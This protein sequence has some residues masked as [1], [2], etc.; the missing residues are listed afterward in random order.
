MS[1]SRVVRRSNRTEDGKQRLKPF[2]L[3]EA[4]SSGRSPRARRSWTVTPLSTRAS[5]MTRTPTRCPWPRYREIKGERRENERGNRRFD[6][7]MASTTSD[8]TLPLSLR[9]PARTQLTH[10]TAERTGPALPLGGSRP[11]PQAVPQQHQARAHKRLLGRPRRLAARPRLR[12]RRRHLEVDGRGPLL[13]AR[14]RPL[15]RG[16]RR[17]R[18]EVRG[19]HG[20]ACRCRRVRRRRRGDVLRTLGLPPVLARLPFQPRQRRRERGS[21]SRLPLRFARRPLMPSAPDAP[22]PRGR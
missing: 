5:T 11:P 1:S 3:H 6:R 15:S 20:E 21:V 9:P 22:R 14:G 13:R 7:Q 12:P 10:R 16:G 4:S 2:S 18:A 17:G 19:G 8:L